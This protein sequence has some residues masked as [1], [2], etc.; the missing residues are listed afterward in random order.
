MPVNRTPPRALHT[1]DPLLFNVK[2]GSLWVRSHQ[3]AFDPVY[4]GKLAI[5]RFDDPLRTYGTLYLGDSPLCVFLEHI[6]RQFL[7]TRAISEA[8][9]AGSGWSTVQFRRRVKLI[10]LANPGGLA[11]VGAEGSLTAGAGYKAP[12]KWSSALHDHPSAVDGLLYH[13]RHDQSQRAIVLFEDR[14]ATAV[15]AVGP[16][17]PWLAN[18]TLLAEILE[19][20]GFG[21]IL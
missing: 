5:G 9:L 6:G 13:P 18:R 14:A 12:Q 7:A 15:E 10:D 21:L 17:N 20:C 11:R 3:L 1:L 8:R 2:K 19:A 16:A 4:F